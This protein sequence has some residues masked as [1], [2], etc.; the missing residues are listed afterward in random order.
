MSIFAF[1]V[2]GGEVAVGGRHKLKKEDHKDEGV[3]WLI[4]KATQEDRDM[5][6]KQVESLS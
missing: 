1:D 5:I 3:G 6:Y 2:T 4:E